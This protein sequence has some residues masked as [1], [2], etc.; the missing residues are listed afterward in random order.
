MT[1]GTIVD[2]YLVKGVNHVEKIMENYIKIGWGEFFLKFQKKNIYF[3]ELK[4]TI[5]Q[6]IFK[7]LQTSF[8]QTTHLFEE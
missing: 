5:A 7:I 8:L 6:L 4:M 1:Y 3:F 2:Q